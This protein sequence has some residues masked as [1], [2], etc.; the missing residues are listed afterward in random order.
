MNPIAI[1][2]IIFVVIII[3]FMAVKIVAE[4][5]RGVIFRLGRLV[6]AR[7]PGLFFIIPFVVIS[8]LIITGL[9]FHQNVKA[10]SREIGLLIAMGRSS[11]TI[12]F[13]ILLK[14]FILGL[15]GGIIGFFTGS[16]IAEYFGKEIFRFTAFSIK[17]V[18][19][20]FYYSI[21][22]GECRFY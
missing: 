11:Y 12:L 2:V 13:M 17:P 19:S 1:G 15:A 18:W 8:A 7:G 3:I 21:N 4:Y 14:A 10:R 9:L 16:W 20:I 6:G 5:E 22:I